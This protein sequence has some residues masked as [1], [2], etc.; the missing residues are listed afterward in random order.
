MT[1][2]E[3]KNMMVCNEPEFFYR[4]EFYSICSPDGRFYVTASDDPAAE[5]L[6][7]DSLDELLDKWMIQGRRLKDILSEIDI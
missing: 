5:T 7:F 4:G 1:I 6:E 3:F 2:K